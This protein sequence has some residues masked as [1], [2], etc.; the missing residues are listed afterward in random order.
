MG[1]NL[2]ADPRSLESPKKY[3]ADAVWQLLTDSDSIDFPHEMN[4]ELR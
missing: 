2:G 1:Y 4:E 3:T